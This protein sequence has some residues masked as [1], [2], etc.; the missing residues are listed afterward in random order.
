M[1]DYP[2]ATAGQSAVESRV[3]LW[4]VAVTGAQVIFAYPGAPRPPVPYVMLNLIRGECVR[5][6]GRVVYEPKEMV[7]DGETVER[8]IER[9]AS[10]WEW[11]FS[12]HAYG[13]AAFDVARRLVSSLG[14]V[15]V[16][17]DHLAPLVVRDPVFGR[18]SPINR[19]PELV[20][21][22]W[23]NRATF[24]LTVAGLVL[25][26]FLIDV[27]ES[28]IVKLGTFERPDLVQ[29]DYAKPA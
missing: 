27:I 15:T 20:N 18:R 10:D 25:D 4:A 19:V 11:T 16:G 8:F 22:A 21:E 29:T 13:A 1:A 3:R 5:E 17:M 12:V 23:E 24:T 9:R 14:N 26:G 28:G 7:I 2:D 6:I